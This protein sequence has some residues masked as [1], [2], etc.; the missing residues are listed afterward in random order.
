MELRSLFDVLSGGAMER[1]RPF[2]NNWLGEELLLPTLPFDGEEL[3][4]VLGRE[5]VRGEETSLGD[6]FKGGEKLLILGEVEED[7]LFNLGERM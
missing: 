7:E 3:R 1:E 2:V 6:C 4:L 5:R